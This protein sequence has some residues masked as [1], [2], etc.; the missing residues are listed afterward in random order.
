MG[1]DHS[2]QLADWRVRLWARSGGVVFCL[3][4]AALLFL[5]SRTFI[6]TERLAAGVEVLT[7]IRQAPPDSRPQSPIAQRATP[8][9]PNAP[10]TPTPTQPNVDAQMLSNMLGCTNP[11]IAARRPDCPRE[12]PPE[13]W[14]SPQLPTGGDFEPE[15]PVDLDRAFTR[16]EQRTLV[17]PPC[18]PGCVRVGPPPPPPSRSAEQICEEGGL[19]G[20]CRP[21]PF[22]PEDET[23]VRP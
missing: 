19:G 14:R 20:P 22:R 9:S 8:G 11:R 7:E 17:M 21:P 16:A 23:N 10:P 2:E 12:P 5:S 13:N 6:S 4:F 1:A 15:E 18:P 3:L